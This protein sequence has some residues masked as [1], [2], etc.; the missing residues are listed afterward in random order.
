MERKTANAESGKKK[1]L[2]SKPRSNF[3]KV[4]VGFLEKHNI[5]YQFLRFACI[6][7][8]NTALNFLILNTVSK[9]LSIN[10]GLPLGLVEALAFVA[11]VVQSYLWNRTW[12][13]GNEQGVSLWK[14]VLR[15]LGVGALGVLAIVFVLIGSKFSAAWLFYLTLLVV[16]LI[17][18]KVLW[19]AFGFHLSEFNHEGH[20][21]LA[22]FI[23]TLIGLGINVWLI[24]LVS[25]SVHLTHSDL[26][27][28]IAA[29][30]ATCVSLIWNFIGYKLIVFKK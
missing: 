25:S 7:F 28:N 11:A 27:K 23:V 10:Q 26:D 5:I 9:A 19:R 4:V 30:V 8:L 18:E 14:N 13:F 24:S 17:F 15:L 2:D 6:G 12:T 16:Y 21:F 29:A 20:S 22:F 1:V 3:E